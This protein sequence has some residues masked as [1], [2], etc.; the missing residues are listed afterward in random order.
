[1]GGVNRRRFA[2]V[3]RT[4]WATR[5]D[6]QFLKVFRQSIPNKSKKRLKKQETLFHEL[7]KPTK[8]HLVP[9]RLAHSRRSSM[10]R[11]TA[12]RVA[13]DTKQHETRDNVPSNRAPP[14]AHGTAAHSQLSHQVEPI[15]TITAIVREG[16]REGRPP[17]PLDRDPGVR[18]RQDQRKTVG[19]VP[20]TK[21]TLAGQTK[22]KTLQHASTLAR[23]AARP[24]P[25]GSPAP[26]RRS[27]RHSR[28]R[29]PVAGRAR[30]E[31]R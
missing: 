2:A 16:N 20:T 18:H 26:P 25:P 10:P 7:N 3:Y 13:C 31:P 17:P 28:R 12:S 21:F 11:K 15:K 9:R 29:P 27:T 30:Q 23:S 1:M 14:G 19:Q 22:T 24:H 4:S 6:A 5:T 8:T